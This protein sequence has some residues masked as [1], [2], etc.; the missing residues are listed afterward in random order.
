MSH[1]DSPN[2]KWGWDHQDVRRKS[3]VDRLLAPTL[4]PQ[5]GRPGEKESTRD[6]EAAAYSCLT[7]GM[8]APIIT[9]GLNTKREREEA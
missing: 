5:S 8:E 4:T 9:T 6:F 7:L 3:N 2:I 1:G